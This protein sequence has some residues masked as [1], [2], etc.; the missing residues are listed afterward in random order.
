[1]LRRDTN[2]SYR[3]TG[4][5]IFSRYR[6]TS[7]SLEASNTLSK[8]AYSRLMSNQESEPKVVLDD[9]ERRRTWWLFQG[10]FYWEHE[11]YEANEVKAL[12]LQRQAQKQRRVQHAV[13]LMEQTEVPEASVRAAI[14]DVVKVF[15]WQRDGGCCVRCGSD[16]RLEFDHIIPLAMG[17][18]NTAR[19]LQLLC[20]GCNRAKGAS[21]T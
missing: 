8:A 1:M 12:V 2:A 21:L 16:Q 15:V 18:A 11:G 3:K 13:A 17:G 20:E 14:P 6:F 19:N 9:A 5:W 7:G 10:E 4:V